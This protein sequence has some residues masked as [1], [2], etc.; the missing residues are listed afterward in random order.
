MRSTESEVRVRLGMANDIAAS[1]SIDA[2]TPSPWS[3]T[4]WNR[5]IKVPNCLYVAE[6]LDDC[7]FAFAGF[8]LL[9]LDPGKVIVSRIAVA[10]HYRRMGLASALLAKAEERMRGDR[11]STEIQV[12]E[13]SLDLQLFFR[14]RGYLCDEYERGKGGRLGKLGFI[15]WRRRPADD[16]PFSV[17][18][19]K[20][21]LIRV[22]KA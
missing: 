4:K 5:A 20:G 9:E 10:P 16:R 18:S 11:L 7:E 2:L 15:K 8:I 6:I 22:G 1:A 12:A 19:H 17:F 3:E 13:G 14:A 21:E